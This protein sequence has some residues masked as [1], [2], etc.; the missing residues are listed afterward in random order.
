MTASTINWGPIAGMNK[1]VPKKG[2]IPSDTL[3]A[4]TPPTFI[5]QYASAIYLFVC[6]GIFTYVLQPL[7]VDRWGSTDPLDVTYVAD[8]A[9]K[10]TYSYIIYGI[11]CLAVYYFLIVPWLGLPR[12]NLSEIIAPL[13]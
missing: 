4:A 5:E 3:Q 1:P 13:I 6:I 7:L 8:N 11:F 10:F 12:L 9:N 2:V